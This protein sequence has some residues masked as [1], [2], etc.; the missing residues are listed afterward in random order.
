MNS[1]TD[2]RIS[3][4]VVDGCIGCGVV[5]EVGG[6]FGAVVPVATGFS[7]STLSSPAVGEI[8]TGALSDCSKVVF[9]GGLGIGLR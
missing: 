1:F 6:V 2:L 9:V 3:G 7:M 4:F 5:D 8:I